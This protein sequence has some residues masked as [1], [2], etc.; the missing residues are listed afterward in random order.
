[1]WRGGSGQ[2]PGDF[3]AASEALAHA[4]GAR[5]V[6]VRVASPGRLLLEVLYSDPLIH[7]VLPLAAE[8]RLD[9]RMLPVGRCEDG[10]VWELPLAGAHVLL[11]GATGSGKSGLV[12]SILHALAPEVASGRVRLFGIDPKG[13]M[14]LV[15]ARSLFTKLAVDDFKAMAALLDWVVDVMQRRAARLAAAGV[16]S[17]EPSVEEPLLVVVI[18]ELATLTAYLPDR[19]ASQH[20]ANTMGMILTKGRAVGVCVV[21]ALQDPRKE[22]V[23]FRNLFPCRV[24][25]R[26][27]DATHVDMVLGD[28]ARDQGA[29][30]DLIPRS[31]AGVAFMRI[32]GVREPVRAR[33]CLVT[34]S[35]MAAVATANPAPAWPATADPGAGI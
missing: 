33:A 17:H 1:M 18:D 34:D 11:A 19:K 10:S 22:V 4:L 16:R 28:G 13:G 21:A 3:E 5:D 2:S 7:P 20:I 27:D 31:Q 30:C 6:R 24:A 8:P 32:D 25:L 26:L 29:R 15:P 14:E 23:G 9:L 12:Y 35:T